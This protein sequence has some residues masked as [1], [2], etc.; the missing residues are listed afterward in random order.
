M[1][2]PS[3]WKVDGAFIHEISED[4]VRRWGQRS[5]RRS[6]PGGPPEAARG[7]V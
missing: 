5:R 6:P 1:N 4:R 3:T 7:A 2:A